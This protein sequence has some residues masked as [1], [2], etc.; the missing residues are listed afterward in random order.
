MCVLLCVRIVVY[1]NVYDH[2]IMPSL[3]LVV[4]LVVCIYIYI[5]ICIR[6]HSTHIYEYVYIQ[7][8]MHVHRCTCIDALNTLSLPLLPVGAWARALT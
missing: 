8:H 3:V 2:A 7:I 6:T 5:Y 4:V 1:Y